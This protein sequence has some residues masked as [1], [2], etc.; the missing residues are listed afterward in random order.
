MKKIY[1]ISAFLCSSQMAMAFE[2]FFIGLEVGPSC[3]TGNQQGFSSATYHNRG[4]VPI[5][6]DQS[7]NHSSLQ[8]AVF[9]GYGLSRHSLYL[10]LEAFADFNNIEMGGLGSGGFFDG[11]PEV[12]DTTTHSHFR[13]K[14][15]QYGIDLRPGFNLTPC[16]LLYGRVGFGIARYSLDSASSFALVDGSDIGTI[17]LDQSRRRSSSTLRLGAGLELLLNSHVTLQADYIYTNFNRIKV[18]GTAAGTT[19]LGSSLTLTNLTQLAHLQEHAFMLGFNYY[20]DEQKY[21][22]DACCYSPEFWGFYI[23]GASGAYYSYEKQKGNA[24]GN[25]P[26]LFENFTMVTEVSPTASQKNYQGSLFLGYGVQWNHLFLAAEVFGL[27]S[28]RPKLRTFNN[29]RFL[30]QNNL[31]EQNQYIKTTLTLAPL[32]AGIDLRPGLLLSSTAL[33]YGRIGISLFTLKNTLHSAFQGNIPVSSQSWDISDTQSHA[34][35]RLSIRIGGGIEKALSNHWHLRMDYC[36]TDY[37]SFK[38]FGE[39][40]NLNALGNEDFLTQ[41][42]TQRLKDHAVLL[43]LSYY[44]R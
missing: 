40:T 38:L 3:I 20:F 2:G 27:G 17:L 24:T 6:L 11:F 29:T 30:N 15:I 35:T 31:N 13:A 12:H 7:L 19:D 43:A 36:Y 4:L 26:T 8:G 23:G 44:F 18:F 10:S 41:S 1:L 34:T 9:V 22:A 33:L 39:T 14:T 5:D 25:I 32:Q 16:T 37:G 21:C 42:N 28:V